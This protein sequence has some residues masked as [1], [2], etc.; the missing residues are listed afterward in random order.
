[1]CKLE[2]QNNQEGLHI[3]SAQVT[4]GWYCYSVWRRS[5]ESRILSFLSLNIYQY[6]YRPWIQT[7]FLVP[8]FSS[9]L[10][11]R[12]SYLRELPPA[13]YSVFTCPWICR[14]LVILPPLPAC[15]WQI[16]RLPLLLN[17]RV[18]QSFCLLN[19]LAFNAVL[20]PH[21][22]SKATCPFS[23]YLCRYLPSTPPSSPF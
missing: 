6:L 16:H 21:K 8:S 18:F 15:F 22:A 10:A 13:P 5:E 1:M 4:G 23:F 20:C 19:A 12:P 17:P 14:S 2:K 3:F 11:L 7:L 9:W